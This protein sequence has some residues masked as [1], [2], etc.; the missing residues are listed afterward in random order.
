MDTFQ[1]VVPNLDFRSSSI[2][3]YNHK[4]RAS[5]ESFLHSWHV[6]QILGTQHIISGVNYQDLKS[7]LKTTPK[8]ETK[9]QQ[10]LDKNLVFEV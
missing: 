1:E 9:Q 5:L 6:L 2:I 3:S 4:Y 8:L 7:K 10:H